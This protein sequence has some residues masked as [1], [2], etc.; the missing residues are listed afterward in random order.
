MD[1]LLGIFRLLGTNSNLLAALEGCERAARDPSTSTLPLLSWTDGTVA[2][3][4]HADDGAPDSNFAWTEPQTLIYVYG[5]LSVNHAKDLTYYSPEESHLSPL[6]RY[7]AERYANRGTLAFEEL[8]G[9]FLLV[10]YE[11][12]EKRLTVVTDHLG[13]RPL[14]YHRTA[15][16]FLFATDI[17]GILAHPATQRGLDRR[18]VV[19]FLRFTMV[20]GD[21]TLYTDIHCVPPGSAVVVSAKEFRIVSHWTMSSS[22]ARPRTKGWYSEALAEAFRK[23][24]HRIV[25]DTD[26][27]ALMLSGGIDSRVIGAALASSG[28]SVAAVSFG[29]FENDEVRLATKAASALGWRHIFIKRDPDY[30]RNIMREAVQISNGLYCF[31]H[32][33]YSG[34]RDALRSR[35]IR[36]ALEGWGLDLLFSGTYLPKEVV[37]LPGRKAIKLL[38]LAQM[39]SLGD[40]VEHILGN[41]GLPVDDTVSQLAAPPLQPL[42]RDWPR[43][44]VRETVSSLTSRAANLYD[45]CD[46]FAVE[47][48]WKFRS[49]LFPL[50]MRN[51]LRQRNPMF[52]NDVID[53][54]L[55]I[56]PELRF[57]SPVYRQALGLLD[58]RLCRIPYSRTG[59]PLTYPHLLEEAFWVLLPFVRARRLQLRRWRGRYSEYPAAGFDSYP[60]PDL[61][62]RATDLAE[63]ATYWLLQ[64]RYLDLDIVRPDMV[65]E[66]LDRHLEGRADYGWHLLALL[67]LACWLEDWS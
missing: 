42:W 35:R 37:R 40:V 26:G 62:V 28:K 31:Y 48:F 55:T 15:D 13:S 6:A 34:L 12:V 9:S 39:P 27:L 59:A 60:D 61:L 41:L 17:R 45:A 30:Y 10:I 49:Y 32:A 38:R 56:P 33:H 51:V 47:R 63:E 66:M 11:A 14:F 3:V 25:K 52:D 16:Q 23:A 57:N 64:G 8:S 43:E 18:S 22:D 5:N 1:N 54:F 2:L 50:S 36:T 24:V 67:S 29:E 20:F 65:R 44:V 53:L 7:I 4:G 46:M 19:E 58:P 21:R